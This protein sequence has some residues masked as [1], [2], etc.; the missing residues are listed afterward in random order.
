MKG[1]PFRSEELGKAQTKDIDFETEDWSFSL[2]RKGEEILV[3]ATDGTFYLRTNAFS[4]AQYQGD[5]YFDFKFQSVVKDGSSKLRLGEI[6]EGKI[7]LKTV[8]R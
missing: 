6:V 1:R 5:R 3:E 7:A 2:E 8:Q 4:P